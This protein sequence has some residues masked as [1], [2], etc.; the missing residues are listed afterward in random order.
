MHR[1]ETL[2]MT[3]PIRWRR[4]ASTC[5]FGLAAGTLQAAPP[6]VPDTMAQRMQ[7]CTACHGKEGRAASDGYYP[8]I[9]GKPADYLYRQLQNFRD[10][11]RRYLLMTTLIDPLSDAY[12][13]EIAAHFASLDLPYVSPTPPSTTPAV[14]QRGEQLVKQGDAARKLPACV[15]CHGG[16]LTGVAPSIPGLLG[17]PRDYLVAQLGAWRIGVR[18]AA[19]PD[20]M[21]QIAQ[22]MAPQ[23]MS[24]VADWLASQPVPA[25]AKPAT[26]LPA[27]MPIICGAAPAGATQ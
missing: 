22:Q 18:R 26:G 21:A 20:C 6:V 8:R 12:L 13:Q 1:L 23:D 19:A 7:A 4:L 10:G 9:A 25:L 27:P 24:A 11:R 14:M 17:L 5:L 15:A 16:S 2:C 3:L